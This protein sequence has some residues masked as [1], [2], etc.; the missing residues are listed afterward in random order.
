ML[1][2]LFVHRDD[3]ILMNGAHQSPVAGACHNR[4]MPIR[5]QIPDLS[6]SK[7]LK[8]TVGPGLFSKTC[9]LAGHPGDNQI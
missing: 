3:S 2:L 4:T 6:V 8:V 1:R 9:F 7:T 5:P